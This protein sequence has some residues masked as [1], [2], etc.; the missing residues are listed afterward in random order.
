MAK[1]KRVVELAASTQP[2][3]WPAVVV[4]GDTS[5][6]AE[7]APLVAALRSTDVATLGSCCGHGKEGAYVD[8]A[9]RG[10]EGL[11]VFV[12]NMNRIEAAFEGR[13]YFEVALNWSREVVTA[14]A[15]DRYPD[16]IMLSLTI[17]GAT[18]RGPSEQLLTAIASAYGGEGA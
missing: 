2:H 7:I 18:G 17:E 15:F 10:L 11:R 9:V 12:H 3:D 13:A 1:A 4:H 8:L 14:C 6:D 16:W 5:I